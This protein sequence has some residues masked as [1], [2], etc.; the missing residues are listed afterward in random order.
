MP[1]EFLLGASYK[2]NSAQDSADLLESYVIS[3]VNA[4]CRATKKGIPVYDHDATVEANS[5]H[6]TVMCPRSRNAANAD[7]TVTLPLFAVAGDP[8]HPF[9]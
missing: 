6:V 7:A 2:K 8:G 9:R 1:L 5:A 3:E 4:M